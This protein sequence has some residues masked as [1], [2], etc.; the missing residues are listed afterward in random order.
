[1]RSSRVP[2]RRPGRRPPRG[3]SACIWHLAVTPTAWATPI[4]S[5][6]SAIW[7]ASSASAGSPSYAPASRSA[8]TASG[9]SGQR[10]E[11][12]GLELALVLLP[13]AIDF[14]APRADVAAVVAEPAA[15]GGMR[16]GQA[17]V[18]TAVDGD[19]SAARGGRDRRDLA[20]SGELARD[21]DAEVDVH[22]GPRDRK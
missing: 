19:G 14:H 6:P 18:G 5:A 16:Q 11:D 20:V 10:V 8:P 17:A 21:L 1:M 4:G 13:V 15:Q 3:G 22:S 7:R 9:R 2:C 12:G